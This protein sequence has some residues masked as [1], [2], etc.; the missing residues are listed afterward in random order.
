MTLRL[1][2]ASA[3]AI[4]LLAACGQPTVLETSPEVRSISVT[5]EAEINAVPDV[6]I[7]DFSVETR[8]VS[9]A[10]AFSEASR[11]MNA[12]IST[13]KDRGIEARDLQTN[14]V[15]LSPV[16]SRDEDGRTD[17]TKIIAYR[18]YQS[19]TVRLRTIGE[20]G[21]TI[22]AAVGAG[23]NGLN[24]F[25]MAIDDPKALRDEARVAA[26]EDARAK[27]EAMAEAAGAKLGPVM[28]LS[29]HNNGM[30]PRP[31]AMRTM[32]MED[33][34]SAP[35]IEAGEQSVSMTVSAVFAIQ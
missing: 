27:A 14:Q 16:Y 9:S 15:S 35:S 25:R 30:R 5:G 17:R 29:A 31:M 34:S 32:A 7:L 33:A 3:A 13:L 2:A 12:V 1:F 22:D 11:A 20:A 24:S 23:A 8:A 28:T 10:D 21:E 26:V 19:L 18:A 6:A 4:A